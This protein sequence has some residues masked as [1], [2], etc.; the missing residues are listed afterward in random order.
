M[1]PF[2]VE[3]HFVAGRLFVS[4]FY[5][6]DVAHAELVVVVSLYKHVA[7]VLH[8]LEFVAYSYTDAVVTIVVIAAVSGLVLPVQGGKHLSWFHTQICHAV[9]QQGDVDA[10]GAFSVEFHP[11]NSFHVADFPLHEFRIVGQL[12]V[13]Q[14]VTGQCVE[15]TIYIP[16]II[17]DDRCTGPV[18]Q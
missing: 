16:E 14:A 2:A 5:L 18:G 1:C 3:E 4:F 6:C 7:D 10:L 8:S 12:P 15:H 11:V 13:G 17:F 9:L